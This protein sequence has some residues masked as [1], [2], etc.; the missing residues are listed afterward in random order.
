MENPRIVV[1]EAV[2]QAGGAKAGPACGGRAVIAWRQWG[3][4]RGRRVP[5]AAPAQSNVDW[6]IRMWPGWSAT[7]ESQAR[8]AG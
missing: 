6:V 3:G 2:Q 7:R 1:T 4:R 8:I 5:A